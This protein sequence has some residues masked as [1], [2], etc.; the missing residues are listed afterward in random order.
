V[1][2]LHHL[3]PKEDIERYFRARLGERADP[4]N[5]AVGPFGGGAFLRPA[6]DGELEYVHGQW[7]MIDP[8][9]KT[10][11][12]TSRAIL[13]NNARLETIDQRRTF[14][15]AWAKGQ[16]CL[17]P[18]TWYQ[19]PNWE[20]GKNI[21]WRL[22]HVAGEPWAL[23]GLWSEWTDPDSGEIVPNFTMITENCDGHPLLGRL[24]KPDPKLP[25]DAQD[26]RAVVWVRPEDWRAWLHGDE[27][28]A[29]ALLKPAPADAFDPTDAQRTDAILAA[30]K[31][32]PEAG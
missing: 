7:G 2:N 6:P 3:S 18:A 20:T 9:S 15:D 31:G 25:E 14:R 17:I 1:C 19:E 11:R 12:P 8:K 21:W 23:A 26:K 5:V 22:R 29:R 28:T 27:A 13:T 16:R 24:H 4:F 10:R 32:A 30:R